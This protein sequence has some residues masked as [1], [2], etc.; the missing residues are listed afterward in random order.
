MKGDSVFKGTKRP[1]LLK[2]LAP[3]FFWMMDD[4]QMAVPSQ[5]MLYDDPGGL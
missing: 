3:A 5:N 1:L 4:A 2:H